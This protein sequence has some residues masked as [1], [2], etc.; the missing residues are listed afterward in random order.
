MYVHKDVIFNCFFLLRFKNKP[1]DR[2]TNCAFILEADVIKS[3]KK[4]ID[5]Q[6][7]KS[8]N[9]VLQMRRFCEKASFNGQ[10]TTL[11]KMCL[12]AV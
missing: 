2:V 5:H 6:M 4:N 1:H 3:W 10:C 9:L 12:E 8:W 11:L 7:R